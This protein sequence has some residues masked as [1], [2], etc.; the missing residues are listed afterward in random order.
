MSDEGVSSMIE[1]FDRQHIGGVQPRRTQ[2]KPASKQPV[3]ALAP[4]ASSSSPTDQDELR[5]AEPQA[6]V[7]VSKTVSF[8]ADI[9]TVRAIHLS[10]HAGVGMHVVLVPLLHLVRSHVACLSLRLSCAVSMQMQLCSSFMLFH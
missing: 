5:N 1:G 8:Q 10:R 7:Q 4:D 2:S 6:H 3:K 9:K